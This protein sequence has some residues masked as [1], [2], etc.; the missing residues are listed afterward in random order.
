MI[1][2]L[3]L[4]SSPA[5]ARALMHVATA[6]RTR[7]HDVQIVALDGSDID[8][9]LE[10]INGSPRRIIGRDAPLNAARLLRECRPDAVLVGADN[11]YFHHR[12]I[13]ESRRHGV[14]SVLVQE[15]AN[16]LVPTLTVRKSLRNVADHPRRAWMRTR[17]MLAHGEVMSLARIA[18]DTALD[19]PRRTI[20]YGFGGADRFCVADESLREAWIQRG[21]NARTIVATGIPA[22]F[23]T[24]S[25]R[26]PDHDVVILTQPLDAG[27]FAPR[28]WSKSF[29]ASLVQAIRA[30]R[31]EVRVLAKVHPTEVITDY[32]HL[33]VDG[34]SDSLA[35]AISRSR[36][37]VSVHSA[38]LGAA[39]ACG[40][41]AI[42]C[43]PAW[44]RESTNNMMIELCGRLGLLADAP[45]SMA[46][47]A[48]RVLD[49][50]GPDLLE[51]FPFALCTDGQAANRIADQ[52]ELAVD[53]RRPPVAVSA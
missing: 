33:P 9:V 28:G 16:E 15:A 12:L 26:D 6:L 49:G 21:S 8:L 4:V 1:R 17:L 43:V 23:P 37:A 27:G 2:A 22:L 18:F 14:A 35:D 24:V 47:I 53:A 7:G 34:F 25:P 48:N 45:E 40:R 46:R 11:L 38:A 42:A 29:F 19:R 30:V 52:V 20:G 13:L 10:V 50:E 3:V 41:P 39:L 32:R 44:L 5:D 31:P 51:P 36:V